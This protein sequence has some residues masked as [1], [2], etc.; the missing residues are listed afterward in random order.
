MNSLNTKN[1]RFWKLVPISV[2]GLVGCFSPTSQVPVTGGGSASPGPA[3]TASPAPTAS[4]TP[5]ATGSIAPTPAPTLAPL[6]S[7]PPTVNLT[8]P[9]DAATGSGVNAGLGIVFST[10]M[11]PATL[12]STTIT[13]KKGD[14]A[15]PG[16]VSVTGNTVVFIPDSPL[17]AS[18]VYT[19]AVSTG[20]KNT[21]GTSLASPVT[22]TFT[23]GSTTSAPIVLSTFPAAAAAQIAIKDA[24]TI[25]F[26]D[27]MDP[28]TISTA[29]FTLTQNGNPVAGT[30]TSTG[31]FATFTPAV[32]M[33]PNSAF[34]ATVTT[35]VKNAGGS[36][37]ATDKVWSFTTGEKPIVLASAGAFAVLA[38]STVTN[39][40]QTTVNGDLG[41]YSGSAA[42]GFPP[43][44]INGSQHLADGASGQAELDLTIAYN[45]A[46]GRSTA[47]ISRIGNL[48]GLTLTPGLYK[49]SSGMEIT[50]GDLT[51]DARGDANAVFIFQIAETLITTAAR[52]VFLIGG[53]KATNVYW[54]VGTSAT[55]GTT[56]VFKGTVMADQSIS[57]N[58]GGTLEGRALARIGAVTMEANTI[59]IPAN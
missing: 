49:S 54:Q 24:L 13:L 28:S 27:T 16:K 56:S 8:L 34:T 10:L 45:D 36:A 25:A 46:A 2:V 11:D 6:P 5:E 37:L 21:A 7:T 3:A 9:P 23:T 43:G 17:T 58:T 31:S 19:G 12:N 35:G 18:T 53:A 4:A 44:V 32:D 30:V 14:I 51:L 29:S 59:T 1:S 33:V 22:W 55:F 26:N 40:G 15:I 39:T 57:L 47:P 20:A 52:Q 41:V 48:G 42:P 38:G 50:S